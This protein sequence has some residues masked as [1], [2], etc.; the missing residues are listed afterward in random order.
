[1][2]NDYDY[3]HDL[4]LRFNAEQTQRHQ[5]KGDAID[6]EDREDVDGTDDGF[7]SRSTHEAGPLDSTNFS[8]TNP[9]SKHRQPAVKRRKTT[10]IVSQ[11]VEDDKDQDLH[12]S[13]S[14]PPPSS[15]LGSDYVNKNPVTEIRIPHSSPEIPPTNEELQSD[16]R[17]FT[18]AHD[19][20]DS[21]PPSSPQSPFHHLKTPTKISHFSRF[22]VPTKDQSSATV[23]LPSFQSR[24]LSSSTSS[25][26][27]LHPKIDSVLP[28]AF[29]PSRRRGA[30]EYIRGGFAETVRSWVLDIATRAS[31]A[32]A[33]TLSETGQGETERVVQVVLREPSGRFAVVRTVTS[34]SAT[35]DTVMSEGRNEAESTVEQAAEQKTWMLINTDSHVPSRP[36]SRSGLGGRP[37]SKLDLLE[38]GAEIM[39]KGGEA[40]RWSLNTDSDELEKEKD[41]CYVA[42]LWDVVR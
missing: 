15:P 16:R 34:N 20:T 13:S 10:H 3:D 21:S 6:F 33:M 29:S 41:K 30:R 14:S 38:N 12:G 5:K 4:D 42:V 19:P 32:T 36:R 25:T 40:M 22:R 2:S 17:T 39:I 35:D 9:S 18:N 26:S 1:M 11:S 28:D 7:I 24:L 37:S 8:Q 31:A 27:Y 23:P